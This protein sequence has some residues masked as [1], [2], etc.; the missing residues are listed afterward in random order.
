MTT[1]A[2]RPFALEHPYALE[3]EDIFQ[4]LETS[5]DGL[6]TAEAAE[7]LDTIGPNRLPSPEK[8]GLLKRFFKHFTDLLIVILLVA[9]G[10]TALLGHW[11]DTGVILAVVVI[12]AIIGF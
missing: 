5:S 11:I 7:R 3:E 9:A 6:K 12:N 8:E 2:E 10:V 4:Q 1:D